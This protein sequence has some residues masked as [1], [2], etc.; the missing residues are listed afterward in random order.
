MPERRFQNSDTGEW[1]GYLTMRMK[2]LGHI[3]SKRWCER[4]VPNVFAGTLFADCGCAN[5]FLAHPPSYIPLA[6]PLQERTVRQ[7]RLPF[8]REEGSI[9]PT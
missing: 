4:L 6:Q 5:G 1:N 9:W 3:R 7:A 8:K 2:D